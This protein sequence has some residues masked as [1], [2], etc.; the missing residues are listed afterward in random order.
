VKGL[1]IDKPHRL[2]VA[3]RFADRSLA[4]AEFFRDLGLDKPRPG[5]VRPV[6]NPLEEG[7]PN[8]ITEDGAR[9]ASSRCQ[10]HQAPSR[11]AAE[12]AE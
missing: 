1:G 4:G 3:Q 2:E 11:K 9:D 12:S 5:L 8:L 7:L 6:E 10:T